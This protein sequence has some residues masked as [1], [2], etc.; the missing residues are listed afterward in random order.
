MVTFSSKHSPPAWKP[1]LSHTMRPVRLLFKKTPGMLKS[2]SSPTPIICNIDESVGNGVG[3]GVGTCEGWEDGANVGNAVGSSDG[4]GVG[5]AVG[6]N[7]GSL[8]GE[9]EGPTVGTTVGSRVGRAEGEA[10]GYN[11]GSGVGSRVGS[12]EG[13]M[14]PV[15]QETPYQELVHGNPVSQLAFLFHDISPPIV[16]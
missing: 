4:G 13:T 15:S 6:A 9:S 2:T 8:D 14:V 1:I 5:P 12:G 10:D 16:A 11:V 3:L 7:V